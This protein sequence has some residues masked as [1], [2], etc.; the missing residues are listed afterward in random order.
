M[1]CRVL[2]KQLAHV[3]R[4]DYQGPRAMAVR[5][6]RV[7]DTVFNVNRGLVLDVALQVFFHIGLNC[8]GCLIAD[9]FLLGRQRIGAAWHLEVR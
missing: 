2:R 4:A 6:S 1:G 5:M 3:I 9:H 7:P 8:S